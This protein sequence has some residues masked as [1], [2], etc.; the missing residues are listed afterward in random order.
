M[1][2]GKA[3]RQDGYD[4]ND[5]VLGLVREL[6]AV[7]SQNP[8]RGEGEIA[9]LLAD[10]CLRRGFTVE[11]LEFEPGRPNLL[12][13]FERGR[14]PSLGLSAHL[15]TKPIGD[16]ALPLWDTNPFDLTFA[17]GRAYGLGAADMKSSMAAMVFALR[18]F[19]ESGRPGS[20]TLVLTADEEQGSEV[21]AKAL[22]RAGRLELDALVVGE[23]SGVQRSWEAMHLISRGICCFE[24]EVQTQQGHSGLSHLLGRN[25]IQVAADLVHAFGKLEL[26]VR[27]PA[28]IPCQP[29]VNPGIFI[30]GGV[31]FGTWPGTATVRCEIR[32]VPGLERDEV[33][34]VVEDLAQRTADPWGTAHVRFIDGSLGWMPPVSLDPDTVIVRAAQRACRRVLGSELPLSAYPGGTDATYFLGEARIPTIASLG[35]GRLSVVHGP[36]E[37]IDV[38]DILQ[39]VDLYEA[40]IDEFLSQPGA[41]DDS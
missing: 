31:A 19:A 27:R 6:V 38:D 18:S 9:D 32:L 37:W 1:V 11:R 22:A 16:D 13:S 40:V 12:V 23:P 10:D 20:V 33:A 14:G 2:K 35:P 41:V 29:I 7:D 24:I 21:G 30:N 36:N 15:D 25:A 26:P 17:G 34:A 4:R 5:G 39:A 28:P 8:G 3:S